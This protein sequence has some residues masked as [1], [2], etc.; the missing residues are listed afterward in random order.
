M[1][2]SQSSVHTDTRKGPI[3][4]ITW[5]DSP[6]LIVHPTH[7]SRTTDSWG[8]HRHQAQSARVPTGLM[9]KLGGGE[10]GGHP[11]GRASE[12]TSRGPVKISSV[13]RSYMEEELPK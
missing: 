8:Y 9:T 3:G 11:S 6:T 12:R 2:D 5:I 13:K 10:N 1:T 4:N 7:R